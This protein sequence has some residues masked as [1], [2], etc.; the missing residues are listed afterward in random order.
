M[1]IWFPKNKKKKKNKK[2]R[3]RCII[4]LRYGKKI[5]LQ[6]YRLGKKK[7]FTCYGNDKLDDTTLYCYINLDVR[8]LYYY[9]SSSHAG[10]THTHYVYF[11]H[12]CAT[13]E[14]V[15]RSFGRVSPPPPTVYNNNRA[16][17]RDT[18]Y[19]QSPSRGSAARAF[20]VSGASGTARH[21]CVTLLNVCRRT[22]VF[23]PN[24]RR[25]RLR[26]S[27]NYYNAIALLTVAFGLHGRRTVFTNV[28]SKR[29]HGKT[30]R[31]PLLPL[32]RPRT[33]SCNFSLHNTCVG[34]NY[35]YSRLCAH[36][37][38]K[39]KIGKNSFVRTI[40]RFV[41]FQAKRSDHRFHQL[42]T[43]LTEKHVKH[44]VW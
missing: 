26:K 33:N 40:S 3:K 6:K 27:P 22:V 36:G 39:W 15:C 29:A 17:N 7:A 23:A 20:D 18:L 1:Y 9:V 32:H 10:H 24:R 41:C 5:I 4:I 30:T 37:R 8:L 34:R 2:T 44:R 11:I 31:I 43:T 13:L 21:P 42:F 19:C 16:V 25:H 28:L 35:A 38:Q 12:L 14:H